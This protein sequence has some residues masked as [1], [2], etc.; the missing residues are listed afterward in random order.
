MAGSPASLDPAGFHSSS[1]QVVT[2]F[3]SA[4]QRDRP[5]V[6]Y[7]QRDRIRTGEPRQRI[8]VQREKARVVPGIAAGQSRGWERSRARSRKEGCSGN[9]GEGRY[10]Y[11]REAAGSAHASRSYP[12]PFI[13][14]DPPSAAHAAS[15][16]DRSS[17]SANVSDAA[18]LH[19]VGS[20]GRQPLE[21][22]RDS[23]VGSRSTFDGSKK[24][25]HE[26][27]AYYPEDN[28]QEHQQRERKSTGDSVH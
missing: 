3:R 16:E 6:L 20:S 15:A 25:Q 1:A 23:T 27:E 4:R 26:V 9:S 22:V 17:T 11:E 18:T 8:I 5:S 14:F 24:A 2:S 7:S 13:P 28:R 12:F 19:L 21:R 10:E